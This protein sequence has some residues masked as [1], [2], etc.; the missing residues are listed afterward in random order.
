LNAALTKPYPPY[1]AIG[2]RDGENYR[3]LGTTLLQIENEFYGTIRPKPR[4]RSGERPLYALGER[5]VEYIEVRCMDNDPFCTIGIAAGTMRFLDIFLLHCL[6]H[7]SPP[8]TPEEIAAISH[9]QHDVAER[10]RDPD[11]RLTRRGTKSGLAEWGSAL[12]DECVP[13]AAALDSAH[14]GSAYRDALAGA[15]ASIADSSRTPSA[16]VIAE[17]GATDDKSYLAFALAQSRQ[18][19]RTL[20]DLPVPEE[21]AARFARVAEESLVAQRRIEAADSVP[22]ETYRQQ[23][24]ARDLLSGS[25]LRSEN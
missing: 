12:L 22:F 4:F 25:L 19:R 9:N 20:K 2:L 21:L 10:G 23:Y 16:R 11:L 17:I 24:L 6:L 3:Q 13:I 5:G 8:D 7:E 1:E 14:R 15:R 18:H